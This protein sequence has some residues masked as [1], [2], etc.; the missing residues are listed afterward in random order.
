MA[1]GAPSEPS[2]SRA[3]IP[4]RAARK[5]FLLDQLVGRRPVSRGV[6]PLELDQRER[7]DEGGEG[8]HV[9]HRRLRIHD[10]D[11][12]RAVARLQPRVPPQQ[13]GIGDGA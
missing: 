11:F 3:C 10:A 13:G 5:R 6:G 12:D 8:G 4:S 9:R 7:L 2:I 1:A